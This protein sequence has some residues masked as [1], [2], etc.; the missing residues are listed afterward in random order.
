MIVPMTI[1]RITQAVKTM[2]TLKRAC[3]CICKVQSD[4]NMIGE[5]HLFRQLNDSFQLWSRMFAFYPCNLTFDL[6]Q[7][8]QS[9]A[10][11]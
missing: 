9:K 6:S 1:A 7:H 3:A 5:F 2:D 8:H 11:V 4:G 10:N